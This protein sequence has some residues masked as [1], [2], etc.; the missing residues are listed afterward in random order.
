MTLQQQCQLSQPK[1]KCILRSNIRRMIIWMLLDIDRNSFTLKSVNK[2]GSWVFRCFTKPNV[3]CIFPFRDQLF[4]FA[5]WGGWPKYFHTQLLLPSSTSQVGTI[6]AAAVV[7]IVHC[8]FYCV[9][10]HP[11]SACVEART[12]VCCPINLSFFKTN[13]KGPH[14]LAI[15]LLFCWQGK[16]FCVWCNVR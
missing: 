3:Y 1:W 10:G 4:P 8:S 9:Y 2:S 14:Y 6:L 12:L 7:T 13:S 5:F 15:I 11:S 16:F